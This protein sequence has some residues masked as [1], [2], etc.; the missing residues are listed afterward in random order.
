MLLLYEVHVCD[1]EPL[2]GAVFVR[3]NGKAGSDFFGGVA[4]RRF[5]SAHTP[6]NVGTLL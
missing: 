3:G 1:R 2:F 5:V 4:H 6:T